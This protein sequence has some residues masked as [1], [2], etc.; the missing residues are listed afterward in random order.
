LNLF[1]KGTP[2]APSSM[3]G[4]MA[5]RR[6]DLDARTNYD[7]TRHPDNPPNSVLSR[8]A[9]NAALWSYLGPVIVLFVIVGVALIYWSNRGP[10]VAEREGH[11]QAVG[12]SG[13]TTPGGF[14][15]DPKPSSTRDELE[16]RGGVNDPAQ[17]PMPGLHDRTA[18]DSI[19]GVMHKPND[20]VGRPVDLKNV[21]VDSAQGASFWVRDG[22]D[23]VEVIAPSGS[24]PQ[25]GAHV[26]VIGTVEAAG[27]RPRVR[28]SKVE[29]K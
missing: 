18:I 22:D 6:D 9:R 1:P 27:N 25:K 11:D 8:P 5:E 24:M 12:T 16:R 21:E 14:N 26:H 3:G 29:M 19:D 15:P 28:A 2:H 13:E 7:E 4:T 20:V 10:S 17:G 23:K